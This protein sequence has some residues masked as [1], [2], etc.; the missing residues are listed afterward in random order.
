MHC[1]D[2]KIGLLCFYVHSLYCLL[3]LAVAEPF[4]SSTMIILGQ[5]FPLL[6]FVSAFLLF[7]EIVHRIFI[8]RGGGGGGGGGRGLRL[9]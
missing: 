2:E 5:A 1:C 6:V 9:R 7:M 8:H 4:I 3:F